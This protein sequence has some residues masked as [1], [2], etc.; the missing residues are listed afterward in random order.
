MPQIRTRQLLGSAYPPIT[1]GSGSQSYMSVETIAGSPLVGDAV[2][3]ALRGEQSMTIFIDGDSN[4]EPG[5][6]GLLSQGSRNLSLLAAQDSGLVRSGFTPGGFSNYTTT[7]PVRSNYGAAVE[8]TTEFKTNLALQSQNLGISPWAAGQGGV[9]LV[10]TVTSNYTGTAAPDGTM[11]AT[12]LQLDRVGPGAGLSRVQQLLTTG[13]AGVDQTMSIWMKLTSGSTPV[14]VG[15]RLGGDGTY[16]VSHSVTDTWQRFQYTVLASGPGTTTT[17]DAQILLWSSIA[18]NAL[19]ADIV[20]WGCQI[21]MASSASAY[22]PTTTVAVSHTT[23]LTP[24]LPPSWLTGSH[25]IRSAP[26]SGVGVD[27]MYFNL[28]SKGTH[29]DPR[30]G[31]GAGADT[32]WWSQTAGETYCDIYLLKIKLHGYGS[33]VTA[34]V[35]AT[36]TLAGFGSIVPVQ[37]YTSGSGGIPAVNLNASDYTT[38]DIAVVRI[39]VTFQD[40]GGTTRLVSQ[41]NITGSGGKVVVCGVEFVR[42]NAKGIA[43]SVISGKGGYTLAKYV[44]DHTLAGPVYKVISDRAKADGGVVGYWPQACVNDAYVTASTAAQFKTT[45]ESRIAQIRDTTWMG[46]ATFI[47]LP[48]A[49]YRDSGTNLVDSNDARFDNYPSAMRDIATQGTTGIVALNVRKY[50]HKLGFNRGSENP[51]FSG[52]AW[53][54]PSSVR[55]GSVVNQDNIDQWRLNGLNP[56]TT[57]VDYSYAS[58]TLASFPSAGYMVSVA[59]AS[60]AAD[61]PLRTGNGKW[62]AARQWLTVAAASTITTEPAKTASDTIAAGVIDLVH[63]RGNAVWKI[64]SAETHLLLQTAATLR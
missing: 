50:L 8:T 3:R 11:T 60:G 16:I 1:Y 44:S 25:A 27:G 29:V 46:N 45:V 58:G 63:F 43:F 59:S 42:P 13:T 26:T 38:N 30:F 56:L 55:G 23:M 2:A 6:S 41:V 12:R 19:S 34:R 24:M 64:R 18:G 15:L 37:T 20:V 54:I 48:S 35:T 57:L 31:V 62:Y 7:V 4:E 49:P 21:E 9:G 36:D 52:S 33:E 39:P 22:I 47:M 14:N 28:Q 17:V 61:H 5:G 53:V 32:P 51:F 10:P 40:S